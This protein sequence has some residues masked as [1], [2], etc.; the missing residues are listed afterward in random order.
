MNKE[1]DALSLLYQ[2]IQQC[3]SEMSPCYGQIL[4]AQM[5]TLKLVQ[6]PV[7]LNDVTSLVL[8]NVEESLNCASSSK[9]IEQIQRYAALTIQSLLFYTRAILFWNIKKNREKALEVLNQAVSAV[10]NSILS[11]VEAEDLAVKDGIK[12]PVQE[13]VRSMQ[14]PPGGGSF[15]AKAG[16]FFHCISSKEQEREFYIMAQTVFEKLACYRH[17]IG[18]SMLLSEMIIEYEPYI[19]SFKVSDTAEALPNPRRKSANIRWLGRSVIIF[20]VIL[21]VVA[22]VLHMLTTMIG[23]FSSLSWA[24]STEILLEFCVYGVLGG[25]ALILIARLINWGVTL[26]NRRILDKVKMESREGLLALAGSIGSTAIE[27]T[28]KAT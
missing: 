14:N 23:P 5:E 8:H 21:S 26:K 24:E 16:N 10:T 15:W 4:R 20:C 7:L 12:V 11:I 18:N 28:L 19:T 22:G 2:Q 3:A 27:E 1:S 13:S 6:E 17:L 25:I 9:E